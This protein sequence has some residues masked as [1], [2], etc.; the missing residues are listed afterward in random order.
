MPYFSFASAKVVL[1]VGT[2]KFFPRK[3]HAFQ[4]KDVTLQSS[5]NDE[6][7]REASSTQRPSGFSAVGSALR[8]GRRV[9]W[10]ESSNPDQARKGQVTV[11]HLAFPC[12]SF[13]A[14]PVTAT[15]LLWLKT[16][17]ELWMMLQGLFWYYGFR[18]PV[19]RPWPARRDHTIE[20]P[21]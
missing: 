16:L 14:W 10:F 9:R 7:F 8:S 17:P 6:G 20:I 1:F 5:S 12:F 11:C 2:C 19:L 13:M 3:M 15:L 21:S 4:K 18:I